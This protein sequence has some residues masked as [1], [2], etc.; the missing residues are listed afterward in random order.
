MVK[1]SPDKWGRVCSAP[2]NEE[3]VEMW[4]SGIAWARSHSEKMREVAI[5]NDGLRL[6][7]EYYDFGSDRC[8]LIVPGRCECLMYSYFYAQSYTDKANILVFDSRSHGLSDGD[9]SY[10]GFKEN[11]DLLKWAEF[12][13]DELG[14][15]DV[16]F[17]GICIG[18][19]TAVQALA[20]PHAPDYITK[21]ILDGCYTTFY[22]TF[23]NHM[24]YDNRPVH[25]V[26]DE[27]RHILKKEIGADMKKQGPIYL[28]DKVKVPTLFIST[29]LDKFSL[30]EKTKEL[31]ENVDSDIFI[32]DFHAET[33]S[34]KIAFGLHFDGRIN[35]IFG[36]HTHVQTND[37]HLLPK[38]TMYISDVGMTGSLDSV[39][40]VE[41]NVIIHQYLTE[42]RVRH[43]P[44]QTGRKQFNALMVEINETTHKVTKYDTINIVQ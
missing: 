28:I 12:A 41:E 6:V 32:C 1:T 37:A 26:I 29:T 33:T 38:G 24:I 15:K 21:L 36:T 23:K 22:E 13:H 19:A 39:I 30:P 10:L 27:I 14:N 25:P 44:K 4:E 20:L 35:V 43:V 40:G 42:E 5:T 18:A 7:G 31:L 17:H 34:E 11:E 9:R 16:F 2:D 3:Q 8:V